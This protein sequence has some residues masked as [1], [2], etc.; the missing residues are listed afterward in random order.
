MEPFQTDICPGKIIRTEWRWLQIGVL[1][2]AC[3]LIITLRHSLYTTQVGKIV[4]KIIDLTLIVTSHSLTSVVRDGSRNLSSWTALTIVKMLP[5]N[6]LSSV[7]GMLMPP[8]VQPL[9]SRSEESRWTRYWSSVEQARM[10]VTINCAQVLKRPRGSSRV[11]PFTGRSL[12][13]SCGM[14]WVSEVPRY[15]L[16]TRSISSMRSLSRLLTID[17]SLSISTSFSTATRTPSI[18]TTY[19]IGAYQLAIM[20]WTIV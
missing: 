19:R 7:Q 15:K 14:S 6:T 9:F 17:T 16:S 1:S 11:T 18:A 8:R 3:T 10:I 12:S 20:L 5:Y 2:R 13:I 4:R